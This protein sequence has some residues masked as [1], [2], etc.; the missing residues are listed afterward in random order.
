MKRLLALLLLLA[1][2]PALAMTPIQAKTLPN[3]LRI[4][5]IEAHNVPM[6]SMQL[7]LPAGSRFDASGR[8]GTAA[9]LA[10]MLT[11]HTGKTA[12]QAWAERLDAEAIQL[13]AG[14]DREQFNLSLTV[15]RDSL[16]SG[17]DAFAEALLHPGWDGKRFALI[18][19]D[20]M[21]AKLKAREEAAT[22]LAEEGMH[23]LFGNHPYG[24]SENGTLDTLARIEI[25]D[26]QRLYAAQFKPQGAVLAVSGD[27]TLAE[28]ESLLSE[29][30]AGWQG[31]PATALGDIA[32]PQSMAAARLDIELP[33]TQTLVALLHLGPSRHAD[34]FF[35]AYLLNHILGGG[36]FSSLL[37]GE[38]REKRGLVYGIY[39]YFEPLTVAGPFLI[40]LQ[41][42]ADRAQEAE[43]VVRSVLAR[44]YAGQIDPAAV[45]VAKANLTGGFVRRIDSNRERV[46]LLSMIGFYSLPLDYLEGWTSR[47]DS[48]TLG[49][50]KECARR[51]LDPEQWSVVRIGPNLG[52]AQP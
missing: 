45:A 47:I 21:A 2:L 16:P 29:K 43:T 37:M 4:L 17:L 22:H 23:L 49:G 50:L 7:T 31:A 38:V 8:E 12:H 32:A 15:V 40:E 14:A 34:D 42:R 41:T 18:R 48:I 5:L 6:V 35:A 19:D 9:L 30:L 51:Y 13:G 36:G 3:G 28:L 10:A 39:S 11:D 24:Q 52:G 1:P 20:S 46:A 27:I 44:L 25:P 33:T 26:M